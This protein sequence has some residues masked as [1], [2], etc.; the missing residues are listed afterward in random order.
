[1]TSVSK[2]SA[3]GSGSDELVLILGT[4][5]ITHFEEA[6]T[7]KLV[8]IR[9]DCWVRHENWTHHHV[10]IFGDGDTVRDFDVC[11]C[12]ARHV[13]FALISI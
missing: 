9:V 13:D 3:L 12:L 5:C 7:V 8:D 11:C 6:V 2:D 4:W 1:M 10:C